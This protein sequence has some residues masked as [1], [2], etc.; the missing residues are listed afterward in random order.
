MNNPRT[1]PMLMTKVELIPTS[2]STETYKPNFRC[3]LLM[4]G[5]LIQTGNKGL[6]AGKI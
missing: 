2:D 1:K 4:A 6:A 3:L 5:G